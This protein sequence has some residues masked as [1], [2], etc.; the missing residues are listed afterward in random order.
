VRKA[1]R[2]GYFERKFLHPNAG[3]DDVVGG[4][5]WKIYRLG[6]VILNFAEAAAEA[7]H[8]DEARSAVNE[9]RERAGMPD[10]SSSLS[11]DELILRIHHERQVELA[12]E[13][14]RYFDVRRWTLPD[15][16]LSRTD[17]WIT[18]AEIKRNADGSYTYGRRVVRA[19]ERACYTNKFLWLP[20]P[21]DEANRLSSITGEN[22]QNPGW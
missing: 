20:V 21:L 19:T 13:G 18:A 1:T 2:T 9:I 22:W 7:G 11:K 10:L 6:E 4:A 5:N 8:L 15:G 12:L 3:N 17:R 14:N 16:D